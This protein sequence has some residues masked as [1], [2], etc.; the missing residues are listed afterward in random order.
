LIRELG[1]KF[2]YQIMHDNK[3]PVSIFSNM[4]VQIHKFISDMPDKPKCTLV[5]G[6]ATTTLAGAL[7]ST[8]IGIPVVHIEAGVRSGDLSTIE[9]LHRRA[10]SHISTVHFCSSKSG[11][12]NLNKEGITKNVFW[13]GDLSYDYFL[14]LAKSQYSGIDGMPADGYILITLHKPI[15]INSEETLKNLLTVLSVY[16]RKVAFILHPRTRQKIQEFD[17]YNSHN[18]TFLDSLPYKKMVSAMKGAAFIITDSGGIQRE[19]TYLRKH[20]LVRRETLGWSSL[21]T[22]GIHHLIGRDMN[23]I[24]DGLEW[25]ENAIKNVDFIHT[26]EFSRGG[27]GEYALQVLTD[28]FLPS[29]IP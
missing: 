15:N 24:S 10:V 7:A 20:C 2:D 21:I 16:N 17:L 12:D 6:D 18:I 29:K 25:A 22:A 4:I 28:I 26:E 11:I 13:T 1:I 3:D 23:S 14:N 5:L 8:R 9:E 27:A 19:A